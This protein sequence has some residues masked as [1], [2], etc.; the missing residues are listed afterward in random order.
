MKWIMHRRSPVRLFWK[1]LR[2]DFDWRG[3]ASIAEF[4]NFNL[5][6]VALIFGAGVLGAWV[7]GVMG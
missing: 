4:W 6:S 7:E 5:V 3:R 1:S 2:R